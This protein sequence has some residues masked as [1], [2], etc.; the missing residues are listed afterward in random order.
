MK[1]R[2][3]QRLLILSMALL[4]I[5]GTAAWAQETETEPAF[6][7]ETLQQLEQAGWTQEQLAEFEEAARQMN[8]KSVEGTEPELVATALQLAQQDR[9]QLE[10]A[11]NAELALQLAV[12]ARNMRHAGYE[13]EAITRAALDGTRDI[14]R[15]ID[16]L[17]T[18]IRSQ[19]ETPKA[20]PEQI[21]Q[22]IREEIRE[23][24][25]QSIARQGRTEGRQKG[26]AHSGGTGSGRPGGTPGP[27][28][29]GSNFR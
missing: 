6:L 25:N 28:N 19:H 20:E 10:G 17:R 18:R 7:R 2:R 22:R 13:K 27:D 11:E 5:I 3:T 14:A 4:L 12:M 21:R 15:N 9:T 29:P 23:Q 16:Q 1:T 24:L 8:W 26:G